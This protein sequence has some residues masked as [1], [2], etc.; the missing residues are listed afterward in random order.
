MIIKLNPTLKE[1]VLNGLPSNAS[2]LKQAIYIYYQLCKRLNYSIDYWVFQH[3]NKNTALIERFRNVDNIELVDGVTNTE[4]VCYTFTA[5]FY[6]LLYEAG[7]IDDEYLTPARLDLNFKTRL[8]SEGHNLAKICLD[9]NW[10]TIDPL[11]GILTNNDLIRAKYDTCP[12]QGWDLVSSQ[13]E[14]ESLTELESALKEVRE[15]TKDLNKL[16]SDYLTYKAEDT[17]LYLLPIKDRVKLFLQAVKTLPPYSILTVDY[18]T[19]LK[20][21]FFLNSELENEITIYA[22]LVYAYNNQTKVVDAILFYN[23][24]GHTAD[25]GYENFNALKIF[26]ISLTNGNIKEISLEEF[27]SLTLKDTYLMPSNK[28]MLRP[29]TRKITQKATPHLQ[30]LFEGGVAEYDENQRPKNVIGCVRKHILSGKTEELSLDD[31]NNLI[32]GV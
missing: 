17:S 21:K 10:Y 31:Y 28:G 7:I 32:G 30:L 16:S 23:P 19:K 1:N 3:N 15:D 6:E 14:E 8:F 2:K 26:V 25:L 24:K 18:V 12:L 27:N 13:N 29:N 4:V 11:S 20:H 9:G 5:I 22:D